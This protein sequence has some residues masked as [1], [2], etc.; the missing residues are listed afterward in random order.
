MAEKTFNQEFKGYWRDVN[1]KGLPKESGVYFV[2]ECTYNTSKNTVTIHKLIYI[3]ESEDVND[4]VLKHEKY[5]KW[6]E[7][8]NH[9]NELCF[10][11][12][13][14]GDFHRIRVEAAYINEHKPPVNVEYVNHFPFDKTRIISH[15]DKSTKLNKDFVV[16]R[17]D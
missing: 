3:G 4:R 7:H 6:I 8:I 5:E 16:F 9:G 11:F 10:S 15:P 2:Y 13:E 1:K 12:T 14:V 17:K